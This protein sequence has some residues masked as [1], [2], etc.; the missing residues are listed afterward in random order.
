SYTLT[1]ADVGATVAVQ[2]TATNSG[3]SGTPAQSARSATITTPTSTSILVSPLAPVTD[4]TVTLTATVTSGTSRFAPSGAVTFT[5]GDG[6]AAV[7]GCQGLRVDPQGQ[8]VTV[9]CQTAFVASTP[10]IVAAFSPAGDSLATASASPSAAIT[11]SQAPVGISLSVSSRPVVHSRTT[12]TA[13]LSAPGGAGAPA[14]PSGMVRFRDGHRTV[15]GCGRRPLRG[16]TATCSVRYAAIAS[17]RIV[18]SYAGDANFLPAGSAAK[19][20]SVAARTPTGFVSALMGWTFRFNRA[21]TRVT[22]LSATNLSPGLVISI[23]CQG[24]GCPFHSR[25]VQVAR[26]ARCRAGSAKCSAP[27]SLNLLH[28]VRGAR[29]RPGAMVTVRIT[30]SLWIG[31]YYRFLIVAGKSPRVSQSCLAV[32]SNRAGLGCSGL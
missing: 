21:Y 1:G 6:G 9:S 2:V 3:G 20:V 24:R 17:H 31:K 12:Y 15:A 27:A 29:L 4:Q 7:P 30:H 13:R 14:Q 22:Q 32:D 28:F 26:S 5:L 8:A 16:L 25:R 23:G 10:H 19:L 18:A 11:V